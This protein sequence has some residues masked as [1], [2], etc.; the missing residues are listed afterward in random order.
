MFKTSKDQNF[1]AHLL[2]PFRKEELQLIFKKRSPIKRKK[3]IGS[4]ADKK[5]PPSMEP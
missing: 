2:V 5:C 1:H 4:Q 3:N